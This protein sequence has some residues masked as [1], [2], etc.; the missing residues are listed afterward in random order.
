MIDELFISHAFTERDGFT[1]GIE[2]PACDAD[3]NLYAVNYARQHTIGKVTPIGKC[4][5]FVELPNGS[6]GNGIRFNSAGAML[7]ADY[8][9]HNILL[10]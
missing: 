4:S 10:G 3:G 2:G 7:I 6:I 5:V 1:S 8:T 9:N